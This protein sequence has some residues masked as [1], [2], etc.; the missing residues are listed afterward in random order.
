MSHSCQAGELKRVE[1][2]HR[3]GS[4]ALKVALWDFWSPQAFPSQLQVQ[5]GGRRQGAFGTQRPS[6]VE[7]DLGK[8][9]TGGAG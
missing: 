8:V 6:Q 3:V 1:A 5:V 7:E 9:E 4:Q 2:R